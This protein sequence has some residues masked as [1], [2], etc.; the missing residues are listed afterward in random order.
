M[1][2]LL[3]MVRNEI[4]GAEEIY[5]HEETALPHQVRNRCLWAAISIT[6]PT[7]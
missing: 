2:P 4:R 1:V 5:K 6:V 3:K 7:F